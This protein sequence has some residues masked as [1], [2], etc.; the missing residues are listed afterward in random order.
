MWILSCPTKPEMDEMFTMDPPPPRRMTGTVEVLDK[1]GKYIFIRSHDIDKAEVWWEKHGEAAT[2]FSRLLPVIRTFISLP[3][4][5]AKMPFGK[6]TLFTFLGVIPWTYAL[7]W[8]GVVVGDNWER[9]LHYFDVPTMII[10]A[11]VV[12]AFSALART[13]GRTEVTIH[14]TGT[15]AENLTSSQ[16][17]SIYFGST[18]KGTIK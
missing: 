3:A 16:D 10:A 8:L 4:G 15:Q 18:A 5:I 9:V 1:Y 2:F 13:Q 7:T 12:I 14:D 17:G 6:F 11:A